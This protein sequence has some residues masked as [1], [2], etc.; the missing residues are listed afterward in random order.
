MKNLTSLEQ[1]KLIVW[2]Y[3][4]AG[5]QEGVHRHH[6]KPKCLYPALADDNENIVN[7]PPIVHW[8]LH[9]LL[10]QHYVDTD[11]HE[12]SEKLKYVDLESFINNYRLESLTSKSYGRAELFDFSKPDDI[13]DVIENAVEDFAYAVQEKKR[14]EDE[15]NAYKFMKNMSDDQKK[16]RRQLKNDIDSARSR[17]YEA[18]YALHH[19][20]NIIRARTSMIVKEDELNCLNDNEATSL[21]EENLQRNLVSI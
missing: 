12:A 8:A 19:I 21:I 7:V 5:M 15:Y 9:K 6:I 1:Y 17:F 20:S 4:R 3:R 10:L 11:N 13:I 18:R 16:H 14:A 2:A